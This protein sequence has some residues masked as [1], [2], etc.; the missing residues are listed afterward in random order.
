MMQLVMEDRDQL[1]K[2]QDQLEDKNEGRRCD[3]SGVIVLI[4]SSFGRRKK[5]RGAKT[6]FDVRQKEQ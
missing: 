6:C 4:E 2:A 1:V 3:D 5:I